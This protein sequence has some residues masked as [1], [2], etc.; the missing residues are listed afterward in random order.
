M[1]HLLSSMSG[2]PT[3]RE[4]PPIHSEMLMSMYFVPPANLTFFERFPL[5]TLP[6]TWNNAGNITLYQNLTTF[7]IALNVDL[8]ND[9]EA[10]IPPFLNPPITPPPHPLPSYPL[11]S[12]LQ[13]H[14][15]IKTQKL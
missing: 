2:K 11:P 12:L 1:P 3:L 13:P 5:H 7:K 8:L 9:N 10:I 6:K 4:I 15:H 14:H